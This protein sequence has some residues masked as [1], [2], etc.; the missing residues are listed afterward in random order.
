MPLDPS[1]AVNALRTAGVSHVVWIPDSY[2]G[3]WEAAILETGS[4]R[5]IRA[6]REGEVIALAAGLLLG[7]ARPMT[8]IQCTGFFEAGDA[9][10]NVVHDL[11]L[12]LPLIV[13]VR[14]ARA[15]RAGQSRDSA[16]A[17]AE[18]LVA[19]WQ[20]PYTWI[21]PESHS[22]SDVVAALRGFERS[23]RAG[24]LLWAE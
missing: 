10:R 16:A 8:I 21:D 6:T 13:G 18:P 9:F 23:G 14:N 22:D 3:T 17:F 1:S 12:P 2:F 5:L 7:G 24:V 20:V 11:Q 4:P 15:F 19:A